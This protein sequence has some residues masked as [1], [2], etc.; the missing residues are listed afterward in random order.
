METS[1]RLQQRRGLCALQD[2]KILKAQEEG[3][4]KKRMR[5][6]AA[7]REIIILLLK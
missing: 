3:M 7:N 4:I 2:Q 1:I 5:P 6:G